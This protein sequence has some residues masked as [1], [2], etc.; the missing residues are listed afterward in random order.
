MHHLNGDRATVHTDAFCEWYLK[1]LAAVEDEDCQLILL[2]DLLR[3]AENRHTYDYAH[4]QTC[5]DGLAHTHLHPHDR[6]TVGHKEEWDQLKEKCF[7]DHARRVCADTTLRAAMLA[8]WEQW[9][10]S[11]LKDV[12]DPDRVRLDAIQSYYMEV[13]AGRMRAGSLTDIPKELITPNVISLLSAE[14]CLLGRFEAW[15]K[16]AEM[17][18]GPSQAFLLFLSGVLPNEAPGGVTFSYL[19]M[20]RYLLYDHR[21]IDQSWAEGMVSDICQWI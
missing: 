19:T 1:V 13:L 12:R 16:E 10:F 2:M 6:E 7:Q 18:N 3:F 8:L 17:W 9:D 14:E 11:H 5:E 4:N 15:A 20:G 21:L